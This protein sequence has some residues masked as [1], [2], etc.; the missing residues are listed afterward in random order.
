[1]KR[2]LSMDGGGVMSL[3]TLTLLRRIE[4]RFPGFLRRVDAFGGVSAGGMNA[5][6]MGSHQDPADGLDDAF[7]LW[8]GDVPLY[9][10]SWQRD[11]EALIGERAVYGNAV[12]KDYLASRLGTLCLKDLPHRVI[13]VTV[14]LNAPLPSG[15][16]AWRPKLF[17][18]RSAVD[19]EDGDVLAADVGV[20][21]GAFPVTFPVYQGYVDGG[22]VANNPALCLLLHGMRGADMP[23]GEA[24]PGI[25]LLSVGTGMGA[26][27]IKGG[28]L[29]WGYGNWLF[30]PGS[31]G[32][33]TDVV[34][35][36]PMELV[37]E[38]CAL[39]LG[40]GAFFR[41]NPWPE[42]VVLPT[43][44]HGAPGGA[45]EHLREKAILMGETADL[46]PTFRWIEA[47]GWMTRDPVA[48]LVALA[49]GPPSGD[50]VRDGP[51]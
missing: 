38:Q 9:H 1:M 15:Q 20:R 6:L 16:W 7:A 18:S 43:K 33:F 45:I 17:D 41:L 36:A 49:G 22:L 39:L 13:A 21:T 40:G 46:A 2:F 47:S 24:L 48:P 10:S 30:K 34:V 19:P 26:A 28:D 29:D 42:D 27:A 31:P 51:Q 23:V 11:F 5:L 44:A 14:Q 50:A 8:N 25:R 3:M 32:L 35:S 12:L 4:S 37:T